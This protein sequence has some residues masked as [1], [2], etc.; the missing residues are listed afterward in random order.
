[1]RSSKWRRRSMSAGPKSRVPR[2]ACTVLVAPNPGFDLRFGHATGAIRTLLWFGPRP[3]GRPLVALSLPILIDALAF[4]LF[5]VLSVGYH[6]FYYVITRRYPAWSA[7]VRMQR[8]RTDWIEAVVKRGERIMAV[9]ALRNLIMTNTFLASTML[10]VIA[11]LAQFVIGPG[12]TTAFHRG[13]DTLWYGGTPVEVKGVFLLLL[14]TLAFMMFLTSLRTLNHL[15]LLVGN[16][17]D[18]LRAVE[19]RDPVLYLARMLNRIE[20][21][22]TNGRRAVYYSLPIFAWFYSPWLYAALTIAVWVFFILVTDF[23]WP[24]PEERAKKAAPS[25]TV[26]PG[27]K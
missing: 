7:R 25:A 5:L 12:Q 19:E 18:Q 14:Y 17:P 13:T 20:L 23:V 16:E 11:F 27:P 2:G 26:A 1:M 9:Q 21:M 6:V 24:G 4:L 10:L 22:T 15:T 8:H 3:C